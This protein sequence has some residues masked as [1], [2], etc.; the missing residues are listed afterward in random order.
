[1]PRK[2]N[3]TIRVR[4]IGL[5]AS[6]IAVIALAGTVLS[7]NHDAGFGRSVT[8]ME[9]RFLLLVAVLLFAVQVIAYLIHRHR[10]STGVTGGLPSAAPS[11][12]N[13]SPR[14]L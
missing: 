3:V 11:P 5:W 6:I 4:L 1:M 8:A 9:Q 10:T 12:R 7:N 13:Q 14:N 2:S